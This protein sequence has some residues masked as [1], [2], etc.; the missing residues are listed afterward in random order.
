[1]VHRIR[2]LIKGKCLDCKVA[3]TSI[4]AALLEVETRRV[5]RA[6]SSPTAPMAAVVLTARFRACPLWAISRYAQDL[7]RDL[8]P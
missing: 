7:T 2:P 3:K 1:M 6:L 5:D 8:W 4:P